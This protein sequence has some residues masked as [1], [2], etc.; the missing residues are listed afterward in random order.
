MAIIA[1][2]A[3][4]PV[5]E[6]EHR[7]D[8]TPVVFLETFDVPEDSDGPNMVVYVNDDVNPIYDNPIG[9]FRYAE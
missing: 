5:I 8:G 3:E 6:V 1:V 7:Q 4:V 2:I 9:G